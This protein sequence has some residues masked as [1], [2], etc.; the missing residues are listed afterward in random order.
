M[1][2]SSYLGN[3]RRLAVERHDVHDAG[4]LQDRQRVV[5]I[6]ARETVAG[7]QRPVDLLLAV[8]PA[9][10]AGEWSAET[11]RSSSARA[12]RGRPARGATA[13]RSRTTARRLASIQADG[14]VAC[15]FMPSSKAFFTSSFFHSMI[16]CAR[17]FSQILLEF[18][19]ALVG[20]HALADLLAR[21]LER[22]R[23]GRRD[24]SRA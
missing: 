5:R 1:L 15:C 12:A 20:E 14:A 11:R 2:S 10:P 21:L 4:A 23:V 19:L 8:L 7:K 13:S 9:A 3:R 17:S 18:G 22:Q 24:R 16:A 6:E